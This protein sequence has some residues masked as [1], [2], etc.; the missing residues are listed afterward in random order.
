MVTA[1]EETSSESLDNHPITLEELE[2]RPWQEVVPRLE[3]CSNECLNKLTISLAKNERPADALTALEIL[4]SRFE[5]PPEWLLDRT[6]CLLAKL[7]YVIRLLALTEKHLLKSPDSIAMKYWYAQGKLKLGNHEGLKSLA[8]DMTNQAPGDWRGWH[9]LS[10]ISMAANDLEGAIAAQRQVVA[11]N[12]DNKA[13]K[14]ALIRM[15]ISN[16]SFSEARSFLDLYR[17]LLGTEPSFDNLSSE[18]DRAMASN[19]SKKNGTIPDTNLEHHRSLRQF[20]VERNNLEEAEFQVRKI[21]EKDE[22]KIWNWIQLSAALLEN[23]KVSEARDLCKDL[24][25][26]FPNEQAA[27]TVGLSQVEM[28]AGNF[29]LAK[30]LL[31]S[32][33]KSASGEK[34]FQIIFPLCS[35]YRNLGQLDAACTI[36]ASIDRSSIPN[37]ALGAY[38]YHRI[39]IENCLGRRHVAIELCGKF[40]ERIGDEKFEKNYAK[41][42][43]W[44]QMQLGKINEARRIYV[45]QLHE[46]AFRG[47]LPAT[48]PDELK[49]AETEN[50]KRRQLVLV[51]V[52]KD[53]MHRIRAFLRHYR[54]LGVE[55]FYMV[56]NNSSDGTTDFLLQQPDVRLFH[57]K[58]SFAQTGF[59]LWWARYLISQYLEDRWCLMVD[60]DEFLVFPHSEY[61]SL[62]QLCNYMEKHGQEVLQTFMLDLFPERLVD[63]ENWYGETVPQQVCPYFDNDYLIMPQFMAPYVEVRGGFRRR[64]MGDGNG[65]GS[66]LVKAALF[67]GGSDVDFYEAAHHTSPAIISDIT[68]VLLHC[69]FVGKFQEYVETHVDSKEHV[70]ASL[71]YR[72]YLDWCNN[73]D[74]AASLLSDKS[75]LYQDSRQLLEL[76]LIRTSVAFEQYVSTKR[77]M[78]TLVQPKMMILTHPGATIDKLLEFLSGVGFRYPAHS[79]QPITTSIGLASDYIEKDLISGLAVVNH[80]ERLF[81]LLPN[82]YFIFVVTDPEQGVKDLKSYA[83]NKY[84]TFNLDELRNSLNR[85]QP[86]HL[87]FLHFIQNSSSWEQVF[88]SFA[89]KIVDFLNKNATK[90]IYSFSTPE[91]YQQLAQFCDYLRMQQ[92]H[93]VL[94]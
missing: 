88:S 56:D 21:I 46:N 75:V 70:F 68:G 19:A 40:R 82:S 92:E 24:Y 67:K 38:D 86:E 80:F 60:V 72:H 30:A 53:E 12:Q 81:N 44:H 23:G 62:P 83:L 47:Q 34:I 22:T 63:S 41:L 25:K 2:S 33:W 94:S 54:R 85:D 90:R 9:I 73:R 79:D 51:T 28:H 4:S 61:L 35:L 65:P 16:K 27:I 18:L 3:E 77:E 66:L 13:A 42:A 26:R 64:L 55:V 32:E 1:V 78:S 50:L 15:L 48:P 87:E 37:Y 59:G 93:E 52:L 74:P 6:C 58:E 14:L 57:T 84:G 29:K 17:P 31:E 71:E 7:D 39:E 20:Y 11:L 5:D 89:L 91:D 49:I 8:Q 36:L 45:G 10:Q 76:G 43:S 69:K